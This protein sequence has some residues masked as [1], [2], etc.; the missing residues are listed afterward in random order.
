MR[1][2]LSLP[3]LL[4]AALAL[5]QKAIGMP[6]AP[7][8][9]SAVES[10]PT[11][12]ADGLPLRVTSEPD[13]REIVVVAER[14]R[15]QVET[16]EAP[17]ATFN[18]GDV[19]ALGA[20]SVGDLLSRISPQTGS[21]RGRGASS[22]G[23]GRGF[24]AGGP[25]AGQPGRWRF[26]IY[27]T[28]QF[29][30][31][32]LIAPARPVLDLLGGDVLSASGT[33]R[34][35]LEFNGGLFYRGL[36]T[37]IQGTWAPST[38]VTASGRP[39]GSNLRFG[40]VVNITAN[41]FFD[42]NQRPRLIRQMPFLKSARLSLRAENLLGSRQRVTDASGAVPLSYQADYLDPRGR[43]IRLELRKSF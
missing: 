3:L 23:G 19:A 43:V 36:G 9:R 20:S 14:I 26:G 29:T 34:H 8:G 41:L 4:S 40:S 17:I 39:E 10:P 5:A 18:E 42:F 32:V 2:I 31:R 30:S 27:D 21:G 15:G 13:A 6:G 35:S 28:V 37:F 25:G 7:T 11:E 16:A 24:G 33:P 1:L 22:G 38:R 12:P